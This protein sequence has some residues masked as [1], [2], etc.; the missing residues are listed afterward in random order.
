M[1][2][3]AIA[4]VAV[5]LLGAC[6]S[7]GRGRPSSAGAP[8]RGADV[9]V[10]TSG[11]CSVP[12][13]S[14]AKVAGAPSGPIGHAG[15]WLTDD[16]G[17]VVILHGVNVVAKDAPYY[18]CAF[19]F[20]DADAA[21]LASE[22]MDVVR[23]GVL[24]SGEMPTRRRIDENYI[25]HLI[26]TIDLLA[27]HHVY[28]LLDWHQDDYGTYFDEPGTAYR[29]DGFPSWM[30]V[31]NGAPNKQAVFPF[32]Y[33]SDPA[34]QQAFQSF[35][36]DSPVP[37]GEGLQQYALQMLV[38]VASRVESDPW[39][40]GYEVMNEPWPGTTWLPC[41]EAPGCANLERSELDT[42]YAKAA[43][44]IRSVDPSHMIFFEPFVLYNFGTSPTHLSLPAGVGGT[45]MSFHQYALTPADQEQVLANS[46]VWSRSTGGALLNTEWSSSGSPASIAGQ[47][48]EEDSALMS[49]TYWVFDNCDIACVPASEA[50]LLLDPLKPPAGANVNAPVV[51]A[52]ARPYAVAVAGSPASMSYDATS[53]VFDLRWSTSKVGSA[54]RFRSGALTAVEVPKTAYP[55]GYSVHATGARVVSAPGA[56]VAVVSQEGTPANLEVTIK[57]GP[58]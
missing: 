49:W 38:A 22:G 55:D 40:L 7:V 12:A 23:L 4:A 33:N 1:R 15:R 26:A 28:V 5:T 27:R 47:A 6:G 43:A 45:G 39:V 42:Y 58:A 19:G 50:N 18:P 36:D 30:T 44:A 3:S 52:L 17:R 34:L 29:A 48:A 24:P 41:L 32:D 11:P 25:D 9:T 35:W 54:Q 37:G 10:A 20:G 14:L 51:D 2:G 56:P 16:Q 53:H 8:A 31:T 13:G 57:P 46:I 21:F